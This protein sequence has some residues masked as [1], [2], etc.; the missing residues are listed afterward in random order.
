MSMHDNR[1]N[2]A[3]DEPVELRS[4]GLEREPDDLDAR[5][6]ADTNIV[7]GCA[8]AIALLVVVAL[9]AYLWTL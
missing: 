1:H 5:I 7:L 8:A 4:T 9:I 6:A 2:D 3:T